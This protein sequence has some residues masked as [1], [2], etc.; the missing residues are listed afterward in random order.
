MAKILITTWPFPGHLFPQISI[1]LAL[2]KRGHEVAF[3]TGPRGSRVVADEGFTC[4]PF[5]RVDEE[6]VYAVLFGPQHR[7]RSWAGISGFQKLLQ[8]WLLDTIPQQ[9]V[10]LERVL[11][12]WRPDVIVSD[13]TMWGPILILQETQQIPV[14]ISSFVPACMIP[15]P[16]A[17]PFGPGLSRPRNWPTR[18]LAHLARF[19]TQLVTAEFRRNANKLRARYD[20]PALATSVTALTANVPLYLVPSVPEFDYD[21]RDLPECV[22]YIGPCLWN[23]PRHEASSSWL[24]DI[25]QDR[26]WVHVTEGTVHSGKP[27]VLLAAAAGLANLPLRVIMTTGGDRDPQELGLGQVAANISV[28]RWASHSELLPMTDVVVTTG[29]AGTVLATLS[30]GVP[31]VIIPTDWDKPEI[32]QRVVEFGA[33]VRLAP[34]RCTAKHLRAAVE[35]VLREPAFS[36]NAKRL[37]A[38]FSRCNGP[39]R[40]V[41][42]LEALC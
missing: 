38:I 26:S 12:R 10:D 41:E 5:E 15:G 21:R 25:P 36:R 19:G 29:G 17:P 3:Y 39:D 9:L 35:Q 13:P 22:N 34:R 7:S 33:G 2:R 16:D 37:A 30:A 24:A 4:F 27:F 8:E 32:A 1:A 31:L 11:S 40:A 28:A 18:I 42:L 14:A 6:K 23:R 20:L